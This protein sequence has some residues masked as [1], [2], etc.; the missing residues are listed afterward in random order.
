MILRDIIRQYLFVVKCQWQLQDIPQGDHTDR[1]RII[2]YK[3]LIIVEEVRLKREKEEEK[4][5]YIYIERES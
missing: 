3:E 2:A 5:R 4:N 1:F